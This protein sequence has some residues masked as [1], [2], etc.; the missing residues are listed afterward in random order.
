MGITKSLQMKCENNVIISLN[1]KIEIRNE[2]SLIKQSERI[3]KGLIIK[4]DLTWPSALCNLREKFEGM[5]HFKMSILSSFAH[6]HVVLD[7][8][9]FPFSDEHKIRCFG[10]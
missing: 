4:H 3:A 6:P 5:V 2:I 10:R 1:S 8:W 7:L 9:E